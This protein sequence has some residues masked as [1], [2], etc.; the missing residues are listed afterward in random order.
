MLQQVLQAFEQ[1]DRPLALDELSRQLGIEP[2]AL[3][4][5][6]RFWVRKGRL[7]DSALAGCSSCSAHCGGGSACTFQSQGPRTIELIVR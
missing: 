1:A 7:R 6:I 2:S 5:M 4:G 3:D